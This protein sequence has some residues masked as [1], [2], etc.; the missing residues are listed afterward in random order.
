MTTSS[1]SEP[2]F[3]MVENQLDGVEQSA[4]GPPPATRRR[5]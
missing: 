3:A 4:T 1:F 5:R 2:G